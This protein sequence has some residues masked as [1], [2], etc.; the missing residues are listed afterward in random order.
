MNWKGDTYLTN[1]QLIKIKLMPIP[2]FK[3]LKPLSLIADK[4]D[5]GSKNTQIIAAASTKLGSDCL[6]DF[7]GC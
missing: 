2:G 6:K 7:K 5:T 1:T 3:Y 4:S